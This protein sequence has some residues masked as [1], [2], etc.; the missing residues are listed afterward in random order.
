MVAYLLAE[1][2]DPTCFDTSH[3][4]NALHYAAMGGH[5]D[6]V[7][8]LCSDSV[9]VYIDDTTRPLRDVVSADIQVES[10][11][12]IDQRSYGGLTPLHLAAAS[13]NLDAV[14]VLLHAGAATLVKTDS[15]AFIGNEYLTA[16]S[17]PLHVAVLIGSVPIAHAILQ[18]H[19][20][21]M[22]VASSGRDE[23]RRRAWEGHSRSDIRSV[24]NA[25]R[26]LPYHLAREREWSQLMHL[27]DPRVAFDVSLDAARDTEHGIGP[28]RLS[29][30]CSMVL[31]KSLIQWL[32]KCHKEKA[33]ASAEKV[34]KKGAVVTAGN[35]VPTTATTVKVAAYP[36]SANSPGSDHHDQQQQQQRRQQPFMKGR[37]SR[38]LASMS[39]LLR[40]SWHQ[41]SPP[42]TPPDA[43]LSV[44]L[45][46]LH[47][48]TPSGPSSA[49]PVSSLTSDHR[50][51][52][53]HAYV[54]VLS[55][56]RCPP[57]TAPRSGMPL[58]D[59]RRA[60]IDMGMLPS[61]SPMRLVRA[62]SAS[63]LQQLAKLQQQEQRQASLVGH[64]D[65]LQ[66][67]NHNQ[68]SVV[69]RALNTLRDRLSLVGENGATMIPLLSEASDAAADQEMIPVCGRDCRS[70]GGCGK[71]NL[72]SDSSGCYDS[73]CSPVDSDGGLPK[74]DVE[75]G[76]CLDHAVEV[77]FAGCDHALCLECARNLTNQEKKPPSCPFCRR[78]VVGFHRV[79]L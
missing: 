62:R 77:A 41:S 60:T 71:M 15:E 29:T 61:S 18:A 59:G 42:S 28:K 69:W 10:A 3:Y 66:H 39:S 45:P 12:F 67:H 74:E 8:I 4:R 23:R 5:A 79:P 43:M 47:S 14:Q 73:R 56:K 25:H 54:G 50:M 9:V 52:S 75:C 7:R 38:S 17:T 68:P 65:S 51:E 58:H 1:G 20:E 57:P 6:C 19:A 36:N 26:R 32:E 46:I 35:T 55:Q 2:A 63:A 11:K 22:T 72:D 37:R 21:L 78:L 44:G 27:V 31:Q 16:G 33:A 34:K 64:G 49:P 24:R 13:G 30:L 70:L 48:A 76:V 53:L 40:V